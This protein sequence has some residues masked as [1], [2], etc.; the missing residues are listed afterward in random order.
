MIVPSIDLNVSPVREI[1]IGVGQGLTG[2]T[3]RHLIKAIIGRRFG[4]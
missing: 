4:R 1:N 2:A 3:D